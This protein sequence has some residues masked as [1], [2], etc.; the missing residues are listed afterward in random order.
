MQVPLDVKYLFVL[1]NAKHTSAAIYD[2]YKYP[3]WMSQQYFKKLEPTK[4]RWWNCFVCYILHS[5]DSIRWF[6]FVYLL[7]YLYNVKPS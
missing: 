3:V 1:N 2:T 4:T 5:W 7:W 6:V